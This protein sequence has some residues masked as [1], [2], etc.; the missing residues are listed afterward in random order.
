M[1]LVKFEM[2]ASPLKAGCFNHLFI[3]IKHLQ[4]IFLYKKCIIA[5]DQ[6]YGLWST[7]VF[8]KNQKHG[9]SYYANAYATQML[10]ATQ[11]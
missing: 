2:L 11:E 1:G 10:Q 6:L 7:A 9:P 5:V 4:S 3:I 8:F